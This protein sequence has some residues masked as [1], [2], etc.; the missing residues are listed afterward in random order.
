MPVPQIRPSD[1]RPAEDL[2]R[3]VLHLD[4]QA[5]VSSPAIRGPPLKDASTKTRGRREHLYRTHKQK[6]NCPRCHDIFASEAEVREHIKSRTPCEATQ[7]PAVEGFNSL[8]EKELKSKKRRPG[9]VSEADKWKQ[10][11]K[12]LFPDRVEIP[13]PRKPA[14]P[15]SS[16]RCLNKPEQS[17]TFLF[18][19]MKETGLPR[20]RGPPGSMEPRHWGLRRQKGVI[21]LMASRAPSTRKFRLN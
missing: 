12:I 1:V 8:Q 4:P 6:P 7:G 14:N 3:I 11:F 10:I 18:D 5:E 15:P 17:T 2:P 13:S 19:T 9:V 16:E 20:L 21:R